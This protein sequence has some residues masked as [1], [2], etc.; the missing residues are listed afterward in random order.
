MTR[1]LGNFE[2]LGPTTNRLQPGFLAILESETRPTIPLPKWE[3]N[4]YVMIEFISSV[5]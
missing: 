3:Q 2:R 4:I 1:N 5:E